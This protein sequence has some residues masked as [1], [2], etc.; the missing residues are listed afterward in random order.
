MRVSGFLNP[1]LP[2]GTR[3]IRIRNGL[4]LLFSDGTGNGLNC[5]CRM[6]RRALY[7]TE[8]VRSGQTGLIPCAC[9]RRSGYWKGRS[10]RADALFRCRNRPAGF[11]LF[12]FFPIALAYFF[13]RQSLVSHGFRFYSRFRRWPVTLFTAWREHRLAGLSRFS[14]RFEPENL[15][16]FLPLPVYCAGQARR[17]SCFRRIPGVLRSGC[18]S[19]LSSVCRFS[20]EKTGGSIVL[21]CCFSGN[22]GG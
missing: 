17:D 16:L 5:F 7:W 22:T 10:D 6:K 18:F 19:G 9:K 3:A 15:R 20:D 12:R 2:S 1:G 4:L 14:F 11:R 13:V 21:L 8:T